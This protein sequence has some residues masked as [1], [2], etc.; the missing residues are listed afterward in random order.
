MYSIVEF[1]AHLLE[2]VHS[3]PIEGELVPFYHPETLK[4]VR[5][6]ILNDIIGFVYR[7][8]VVFLEPDGKQKYAVLQQLPEHRNESLKIYINWDEMFIFRVRIV[9]EDRLMEEVNGVMANWAWIKFPCSSPDSFFSL[10]R[11]STTSL[12]FGSGMM[13]LGEQVSTIQIHCQKR[14]KFQRHISRRLNS[15][16]GGYAAQMVFHQILSEQ[17]LG[18]SKAD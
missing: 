3:S 11:N 4:H 12:A 6:M 14:T 5:K 18:Y 17:H 16:L 8:A 10:R 1:M 7:I 13:N 2:N 15:H 9:P